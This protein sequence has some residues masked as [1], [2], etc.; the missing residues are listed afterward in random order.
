[1]SVGDEVK[2]LREHSGLTQGELGAAIGATKGY[3]SQL[4]KGQTGMSVETLYRL[5]T[6]L[7]VGCDH[8]AGYF[9]P[10]PAAEQPSA[11]EVKP[12]AKGKRK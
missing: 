9:S 1:M 3:V 7:S 6:A 12:V 4:E 11:Q 2:K 5:C 8:F 10:V